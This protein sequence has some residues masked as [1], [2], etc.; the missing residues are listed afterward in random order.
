[1]AA[2]KKEYRGFAWRGGAVRG[3]PA[4]VSFFQGGVPRFDAVDSGIDTLFDCPSFFNP[5]RV[6]TGQAATGPG[7]DPGTRHLYP[8][9][10]QL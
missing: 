3:D 1:M 9:A 4:L 2:I 7:H 5:R 10:S 8:D 6:R